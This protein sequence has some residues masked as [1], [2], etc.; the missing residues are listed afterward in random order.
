MVVQLVARQP[1]SKKVLG[2]NPTV[3]SAWS[4]EVCMFS[5]YM[6]GFS[7]DTLASSHSPKK[8]T[9]F[10]VCFPIVYLATWVYLKGPLCAQVIKILL[11][12]IKKLKENGGDIMMIDKK[13]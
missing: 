1:C 10:K 8:M 12:K 13:E 5:P 9:V 4:H 6:T 3:G 2:S 7:T 11:T